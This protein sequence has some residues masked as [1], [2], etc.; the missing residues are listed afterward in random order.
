MG[1][2]NQF[3]I[4]GIAACCMAGISLLLPCTISGT[5]STGMPRKLSGA[6]ASIF[7]LIGSMACVAVA[8]IFSSNN[9]ENYKEPDLVEEHRLAGSNNCAKCKGCR[10]GKSKRGCAPEPDQIESKH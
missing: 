10:T 7:F 9:N 5:S 2:L 4:L 8:L 1:Q 3:Q 6:D